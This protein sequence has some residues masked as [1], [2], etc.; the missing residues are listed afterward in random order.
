M[1]TTLRRATGLPLRH[2]RPTPQAGGPNAAGNPRPM[3][4]HRT[5][6]RSHEPT[7]A[8]I[9]LA[10]RLALALFYLATALAIAVLALN[11]LELALETFDSQI[12]RLLALA[13][14]PADLTA[15][16]GWLAAQPFISPA[17]QR[18]TPQ[19]GIGYWLGIAGALMMLALVLYRYRK[20]RPSM[21]SWGKTGNWF[22]A[23][24]ILGILGPTLILFHSNLQ[25]HT[26]NGLRD[27]TSMAALTMM[28]IVVL[29]GVVSRYVYAGGRK[30]ALFTAWQFLHLPLF[31]VAALAMVVHVIAV[32][33]Y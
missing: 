31:L 29:S 11:R 22:R 32:H 24:E 10:P 3:P 7:E 26:G 15:L 25:L 18:M 17:L 13:L 27:I 6:H 21:R 1:T 16:K 2:Q 8:R 12:T 5:A 30:G 20:R 9:A 4:S 28:L 19:S 14:S 33:L 23:H